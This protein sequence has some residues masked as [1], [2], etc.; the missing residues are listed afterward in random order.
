MSAQETRT[1]TTSAHDVARDF[2]LYDEAT[3]QDPHKVYSELRSRC[4]V[5]HSDRDDGFWIATRYE[6]VIAVTKD[7][8]T[9]SSKYVMIPRLKFGP[10]FVDRP[11]LTADEPRHKVYR[12]LLQP[13]FSHGKIQKWEPEIRKIC[14]EAVAKVAP[15][16]RCDAATDFAKKIPLGFTC[17]LLGVSP[18]MEPR[19]TQWSKDVV[20]SEDPDD[21]MRAVGDIVAFL[22]EQL[23]R[24]MANPTEDLIS[25]LMQSEVDGDKLEGQEL[26]AVLMVVMIAGLDTTWA[27]L[28]SCMYHLAAHPEDCRRLVDNPDMIPTAV[29]ELLRFY[30][31]VALT[32]ETTTETELGGI[33]IGEKELV[34]LS[35]PAANR[36][37][38]IFADPDRVVIDRAENRHVTFGTGIHRCLGSAVARLEIKV[39]IEEWLAAIP[40]FEL[41][42]PATVKYATGHVWGPRVVDVRYPENLCAGR[43]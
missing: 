2:S 7:A 11:P 24:R 38:E 13:I 31:P 9:Y 41:A 18:E 37:P 16:G 39:A 33:K 32:R 4:P 28:S 29:E 35:W 40:E 15:L 23:E 1:T 12:K 26:L 6:D 3:M 20:E 14:R 34:L 36:D 30:A 22:G 17:A 5:A 25:Q 27:A 42:D 43:S 21:A 10:D 8:Q 19:F